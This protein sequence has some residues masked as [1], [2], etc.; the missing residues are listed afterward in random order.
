MDSVGS[1]YPFYYDD[2]EGV[3]DFRKGEV[4]SISGIECPSSDRIVFKLTEPV[5]DWDFRMAMPATSPVP[6]A[7]A[8]K[9]DSKDDSE[10][11]A[12]VVATG[13]YY[14]SEWA[15]GERIQME[16]NP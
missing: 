3:D 14:I 15:P 12:H 1:G 5:G 8:E 11:D 13:P 10:Y 9:Y 7:A 16:R 6:R 4:D 2:L